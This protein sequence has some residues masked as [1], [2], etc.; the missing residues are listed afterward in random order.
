VRARSHGG[1]SRRGLDCIAASI[2][3]APP[4]GAPR[5]TSETCSLPPAEDHHCAVA[6]SRSR[7]RCVVIEG[8][9][10]VFLDNLYALT[11]FKQ[12]LKTFLG[13]P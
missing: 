2:Y 5:D 6:V 10:A 9:L 1:S 7:E 12:K 3:L 13:H 8:V 4:F 11:D